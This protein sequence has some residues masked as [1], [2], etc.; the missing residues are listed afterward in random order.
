MIGAREVD[1]LLNSTPP[2]PVRVHPLHPNMNQQL[3]N[4]FAQDYP[5]AVDAA[6]DSTAQRCRFN[7]TR[8]TWAG[9]LL[10]SGC[11]DGL[12][13]V[14]DLDTKEAIRSFDGHVKAVESLSWS[15]HG[16]YLLSASRD[17]KCVVWDLFYTDQ[18]MPPWK[19]TRKRKTR[20]ELEQTQTG[21]PLTGAYPTTPM[22]DSVLFDTPLTHAELHP[23]TSRIILANTSTHQVALVYLP[24]FVVGAVSTPRRR[25]CWLRDQ[26]R[27]EAK[28]ALRERMDGIT[29]AE[30]EEKPKEAPESFQ[31]AS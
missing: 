11:S 3:L 14:V 15:R 31:E 28:E 7:K 19:P 18:N 22:R 26:T 5:D 2:R 10:A 27:E 29:D 8:G 4:P 17:W 12:V 6:I 20:D 23:N 16:R 13:Q 1:P 24:P 9:H 30:L 25:V 21:G